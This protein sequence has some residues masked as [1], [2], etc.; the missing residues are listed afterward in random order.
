[1]LLLLVPI[2]HH[3][4]SYKSA[5]SSVCVYLLY[6]KVYLLLESNE[7]ADNFTR[8]ESKNNVEPTPKTVIVE[9]YGLRKC[10]RLVEQVYN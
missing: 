1:V 6:F 9:A 10:P 2:Y 5:H 3:F 4:N 7:M 8:H